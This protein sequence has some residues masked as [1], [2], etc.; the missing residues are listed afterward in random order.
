VSPAGGIGRRAPR[1]LA[2]ALNELTTA[3]EPAKYLYIIHYLFLYYFLY[4][5]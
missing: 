3:L 5:I 2:G 4:Y 1:P